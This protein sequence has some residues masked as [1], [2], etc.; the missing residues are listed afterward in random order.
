MSA[1][2]AVRGA[3]SVFWIHIGFKLVAEDGRF[4]NATVC[5]ARCNALGDVAMLSPSQN[6]DFMRAMPLFE[7]L[8]SPLA[9]FRCLLAVF[10]RF[11]RCSSLGLVLTAAYRRSALLRA[12][13]NRD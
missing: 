6:G 2:V 8:V 9:L 11:V 13:V 3:T 5:I 7:H 1:S 4:G 12:R 10:R